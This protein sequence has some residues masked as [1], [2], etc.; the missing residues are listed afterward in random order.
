MVEFLW[1]VSLAPTLLDPFDLLI[2]CSVVLT[3]FR[4]PSWLSDCEEAQEVARIERRQLELNGDLD[5]R[6]A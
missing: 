2:Q 1:V 3:V 6:Q 5:D 4:G